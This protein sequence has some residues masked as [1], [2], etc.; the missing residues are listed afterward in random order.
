MLLNVYLAVYFDV[1]RFLIAIADRRG[2]RALVLEMVSV[3]TFITVSRHGLD[4]LYYL[5]SGHGKS[6]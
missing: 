6:Y 4:L 1:A 2:A 5:L 3:S